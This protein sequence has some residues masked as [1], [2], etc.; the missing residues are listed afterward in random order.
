MQ[1]QHDDGANAG[2]DDAGVTGVG[3]CLPALQRLDLSFCELS[4]ETLLRIVVHATQ[5]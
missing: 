2:D 4:E 5:P 3:V 1:G